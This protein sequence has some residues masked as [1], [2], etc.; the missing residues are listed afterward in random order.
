MCGLIW[1]LITV[2]KS[3]LLLQSQERKLS[4]IVLPHAHQSSFWNTLKSC[5]KHFPHTPSL[6]QEDYSLP[7]KR[8]ETTKSS[9]I[10]KTRSMIVSIFQSLLVF[11]CDATPVSKIATILLP[12]SNSWFLLLSTWWKIKGPHDPLSGFWKEDK[13]VVNWCHLP[14]FH[15]WIACHNSML[16]HTSKGKPYIRRPFQLPAAHW[17]FFYGT[18]FTERFVFFLWSSCK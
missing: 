3:W 7:H 13:A 18:T 14:C 17:N 1:L 10:P 6:F 9:L 8:L 11:H 12:L 15:L 5:S 2:L 16:L 4:Q